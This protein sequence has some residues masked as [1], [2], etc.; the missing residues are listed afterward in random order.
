[1]PQA[2][3]LITT[4]QT[5]SLGKL[6]AD[7][8]I[9]AVPFAARYRLLD[10]ALSN[11]V[12][13]GVRTVG[14]ITPH[15][16][17]PIMDHLGAG[18]EWFLDRKAGGLFILPGS[19][20]GMKNMNAKFLLK[21]LLKNIQYI[22]HGRERDVVVSSANQV[23]N[24]NYRPAL[25]AH[26]ESGADL[27][28]LYRD[29]ERSLRGRRDNSF[30]LRLGEDGRVLNLEP[31]A[32]LAP[33]EPRR[34]FLDVFIMRRALLLNVLE[35]YKTME[36]SD[37][38]DIIA[39][40]LNSWQ[41]RSVPFRGYLKRIESVED[42]FSS[43]MDCLCAEV[44]QEIFGA[45][46]RIHTKMKDNAPAYYGPQSEV[47]NSLV[48]SGCR[49]EGSV[50]NSIIFRKVRVAE[51]AIVRDSVVMQ[52]CVIDQDSLVEHVVCDKSA[53]IMRGSLLK[54]RLSAPSVVGKECVV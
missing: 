36:Y 4:N 7:R 21:D 3:G 48:A 20:Y 18:R 46:D 6:T 23:F 28:L 51:G 29:E 9:A 5:V 44:R 15:H 34:L 30:F 50:A 32:A 40:N 54:G 35:W 42:Y 17:R 25:E 33:R 49:I 45:A 52:G 11:L 37:L 22:R 16:F 53:R 10:F 27:T 38:Q 26:A 8:P 31:A 39:E 13:S 41:V 43:S 1:M 14:L 12:N 24:F 2:M 47:T 19:T